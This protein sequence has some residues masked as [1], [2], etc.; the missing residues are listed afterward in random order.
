MGASRSHAGLCIEGRLRQHCNTSDILTLWN[1]HPECWNRWEILLSANLD[2]SSI[3][4]CS[5]H[6]F[7][8]IGEIRIK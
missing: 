8:Q 5:A 7:G 4:F 6:L 3:V 2:N 1:G